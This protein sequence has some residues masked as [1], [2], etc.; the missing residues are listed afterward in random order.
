VIYVETW[1][2]QPGGTWEYN[3]GDTM[4]YSE[5]HDLTNFGKLLHKEGLWSLY[6][7]ADEKSLLYHLCRGYQ[8]MSQD[9]NPV[10]PRTGQCSACHKEAPDEIRGL[11][12]LHNFEWIQRS[13]GDV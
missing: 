7:Y 8:G 1:T 4:Y 6:A 5:I 12:T 10:D 3:P 11:W 9:N 2:A 13:A